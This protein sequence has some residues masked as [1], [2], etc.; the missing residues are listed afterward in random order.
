MVR[1]EA[2]SRYGA[3]STWE[4]IYDDYSNLDP[5][6]HI[7]FELHRLGLKINQNDHWRGFTK[8][9]HYDLML[10]DALKD[11]LPNLV[12]RI[13]PDE[14][15]G[16]DSAKKES[17][18]LLARSFPRDYRVKELANILLKQVEDRTGD[19]SVMVAATSLAEYSQLYRVRRVVYKSNEWA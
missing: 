7:Q 12:N 3:N 10:A 18:L 14:L 5:N 19:K 16:F 4:D 15:H 13:N 9:P 2:F 17:T 1:L 6:P 11:E 8:I